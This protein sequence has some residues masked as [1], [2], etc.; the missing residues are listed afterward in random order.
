MEPA[1][2]D[3]KIIQGARFEQW[4]TL[5][6]QE[7]DEV[8]IDVREWEFKSQ[9]RDRLGGTLK[10]EFQIDKG[11]A[12]QGKVGLIASGADTAQLFKKG[13]YDVF[14]IRDGKPWMLL[15]GV[16]EVQKRSTEVE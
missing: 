9:M 3:I 12:S 6:E 15:Y 16:V 2:Y 5:K 13:V 7:S 4:F 14:V 1:E 11:F 8:G 10:L